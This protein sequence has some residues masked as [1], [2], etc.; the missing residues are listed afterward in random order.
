MRFPSHWMRLAAAAVLALALPARAQQRLDGLGDDDLER[1]GS[2]VY[3]NDSFEAADA[4]RRAEE[5]LRERDYAA[6]MDSFQSVI[7]RF[8]DKLV[9]GGDGRYIGLVRHVQRRIA[10]LP[11]DA[12]E[13]YR[14]RFG[15]KAAS[16]AAAPDN[17]ND[18]QALL[19]LFE[20]YFA[21]IQAA[22]MAD[23]IA[24]LALEDG[25]FALARAV[26]RRVIEEHPDRDAFGP[27]YRAS[28]AVVDALGER[29]GRTLPTRHPIDFDPLTPL[30]WMGQ[31]RAVGEILSE[32][33]ETDIAIGLGQETEGWPVVGG[34]LRHDRHS[35]TQVDELGLQ[36][37]F[38]D[39][40]GVS[41]DDGAEV[42][43]SADATEPREVSTVPVTYENL[44]IVQRFR[45]VVALRRE[46]G[47][48][49][50]RFLPD[51]DEVDR[52]GY[53]EDRPFGW[54]APSVSGDRVYA[55]LPGDTVAYYSYDSLRSPH[56]LVCLD[57][58]T[59]KV[60]WR[61][62]ET[63]RAERF[64]ELHFD[65]SPLVSGDVLYVVGRRRRSFGFEDCYLFR[66]DA[67][68]GALI[69]QTHIG[70]ASTGSFGARPLTRT[71]VAIDQSSVLVCS[72]IGT[73]ASIDAHTGRVNWLRLYPRRAGEG[74]RIS[75]RIENDLHPWAMNEAMVSGGKLAIF[76]TDSDRVFIL[77]ALSGTLL[78]DVSIEELGGAEQIVC[79]EGDVLCT[80]SSRV[81]CFD[82]SAHSMRW[83]V[84]LP[85]GREIF[86]RSQRLANR[87]AVPMKGAIGF[88][89]VEDGSYTEM[90]L[91]EGEVGGNL[92]VLP[93]EIIV[94]GPRSVASYVRKADIW[95]TLRRKLE[96]SPTDP[97]AAL[98]LA[99][100]A[101]RSGEIEEA[102]EALAEA[103]RRGEE[104]RDELNEAVQRRL[105]STALEFAERLGT[106]PKFDGDSLDTLLSIAAAHAPTP[107]DHVRLRVEFAA[108]HDRRGS[109]DRALSLYQQILRDKSLRQVRPDPSSGS[110][111]TVAAEM[112]RRIADLLE[113]T[114]DESLYAPYEKEAQQLLNGALATDDQELLQRV[115]QVFPN[116]SAAPK[117]LVRRGDLFASAGDF[118]RAAE[119]YV[120]AYHRF[121]KK[122]DRP[123][124]LA[125]IGTSFER[126]GRLELAYRWLTKA[127]REHPSVTLPIGNETTSFIAYR[128]ERLSAMKL[129]VEP[130]LPKTPLPLD[131]AF[132]REFSE[133]FTLLTPQVGRAPQADWSRAYIVTDDGLLAIDPKTGENLWPGAVAT[134][135][136]PNLL[137]ASSHL[138]LFAT[139]HRVFAL[140]ATTGRRLW[141]H[142][143]VPGGDGD[144]GAD[145]EATGAFRTHALRGDNLYSVRSGGRMSCID[146]PTGRVRWETELDVTPAGRLHLSDSAIAYHALVEGTAT[147]FLVES[148]TGNLISKV[149]TNEPRAAE[150]AF[151]TLDGQVIVVTSS[152][153][154]ALDPASGEVNWRVSLA[155]PIRRGRLILDLDALYYSPDNR[156]LVK[157]RIEDGQVAWE[158]GEIVR[159]GEDDLRIRQHDAYLFLTTDSSTTAVDAVTGIT[160]WRG[161]VPERPRIASQ[162]L[163]EN[164]VVAIDLAGLPDDEPA[165]AWFYDHRNASGRIPADGAPTLGNPGDLREVLCTDVSILMQDGATTL[166]GY[167]SE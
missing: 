7:E 17:A 83:S 69:G 131:H 85:E 8:G 91:G 166:L 57:A 26:Y 128:D 150:H 63:T 75:A 74:G 47:T 122:L 109:A 134:D 78:H 1:S 116:S 15:A 65:T 70:S 11:E 53:I 2:D 35:S 110:G 39:W 81:G 6:A 64:A 130:S 111:Q 73:I 161:A 94:A 21:T 58:R 127:A 76:P 167:T 18:A 129:L 105:F 153:M 50:W 165:V 30:R 100:V 112:E 41:S 54:D 34:N 79:L 96:T 118:G 13:A 28:L 52:D 32:I 33:R 104:F 55:S 25:D 62:E 59:G 114:N 157:R 16:L 86:G 152:S 31:R 66:F 22:E 29:L 48:V 125:K 49:A 90:P 27:G 14:E 155:A 3:L 107:Q 24:Q 163:T 102:L 144:A 43:E 40:A 159:R 164:Y 154:V 156:S 23:R 146:I 51:R 160:L 133:P 103:D 115:I 67:R 140:D 101:L 97:S 143:E 5:L 45:E 136:R 9:Q 93:S 92:L 72:N 99:E 124:L 68:D 119:A 135:A 87:I 98:E 37:R 36:W 139:L 10:T 142:G 84:E 123:E 38:R 106:D 138:A 60:I 42:E 120:S 88:Y 113:R 56:E 71:V 82:L 12:V 141:T 77:D 145:W 147:A 89:S 4:L 132:V 108:I 137:F 46:T 158:T 162:H 19:V 121:G 149:Q 61:S 148:A 20:D 151:V 80:A 126:A 117:A 95:N 44:I